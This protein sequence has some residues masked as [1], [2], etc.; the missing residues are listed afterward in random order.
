MNGFTKGPGRAAGGGVMTQDD[1]CPENDGAYRAELA[2][3]E[4]TRKA[5]RTRTEE[6]APDLLKLLKEARE[7]GLIYWKPNTS[8][9]HE[10]KADMFA[11]IDQLIAKAEGR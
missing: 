10:R 11:R 6:L 4:R 9:G 2:E 5:D 7:K 3:R 8:R 1:W